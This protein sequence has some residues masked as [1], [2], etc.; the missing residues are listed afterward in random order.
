MYKLP[1]SL[2]KSLSIFVFSASVAVSAIGVTSCSGHSSDELSTDVFIVGGGASGTAAGVQAARMGVNVIIAEQTP[3][4][5]GMLTSAGVSA[6]DGN[7]KMP[8]GFFGEFRA[9]LEDYYGGPEGINTG[10]VSNVLFE[11]SVGDKMLKELA[12]EE[13][14]LD[15]IYN[16]ETSDVKYVDKAWHA[17]LT[18]GD[19]RTQQV[20]AKILIDGT[21]LGD[22][23]ASVGVGY[24]LGI[25]SRHVTGE[26]IAPDSAANIIQDLTMVAILKDYGR[27]VTIDEP[28]DY[29]PDEFACT[30][31]NDHCVT[32]KEP[33]RMWAREDIIT[34]GKLPNGKYMINWP[35]EGNDYYVNMVEMTPAQ[36]DSAV[37]EAKAH[38]MRYIY[39]LQKELGFNNL[40]LADD[41]F[42]TEDLM[43]FIPYHRE[44]RRIHGLVRFD[45]NHIMN[46]YA[47][48]QPLYRT[49]IAVGDYPVDQHH[50]AYTGSEELPDLHFHPVPSYGLPMGTLIPRDVEDLIVTEKSI[51]V[52]NIVN[53]STRLQPVVTQ[54]GQAAGAIAA[55]AVRKGIPVSKVDV[56]Q[57]QSA[58]L[59][60]NGYLLPYLDVVKTDPRFRAYQRIGATGI[61]RSKGMTIDW[62]NQT[63]LRADEPLMLAE[64]A[65]FNQFYGI[66]APVILAERPVTLDEAVALIEGVKGEKIDAAA[67]LSAFGVEK[68]G[69]EDITRGEFALLV[70]SILN[71]FARKVGIDG[72]FINE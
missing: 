16:V 50:K 63:W 53:G 61:L 45:A 58:I 12:A 17:T 33:N 42:P 43:P 3:W 69:G 36:R 49:T 70:D 19:G 10:W 2:A 21:E 34:Y 65:D 44:S 24:D 62:T 48:E 56:R 29:D 27:D 30:C 66:S 38:T 41:E 15:I 4:L 52:T 59:D 13:R 25:E 46:P 51:S 37:A 11:P 31:I 8:A 32:P 9:K 55:L 39:F 64:L 26:D 28:E 23:A 35:I 1:F 54:L 60:A 14:N 47:T 72:N 18:Y 57:V 68:G 6:V 5:G 7:Y 67:V 71:P 22:V 40:G 20:K